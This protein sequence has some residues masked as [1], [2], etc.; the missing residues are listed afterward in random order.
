MRRSSRPVKFY[1]KFSKKARTM[2]DDILIDIKKFPNL[3]EQ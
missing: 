3:F 1:K 2:E